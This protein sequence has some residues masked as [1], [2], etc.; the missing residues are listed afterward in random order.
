M[1]GIS[2][3]AMVFAFFLFSGAVQ[4]QDD[5]ASSA[6]LIQGTVVNA[7]TNEGI[8][9]ALVY[10]PDNRFATLTDGQGHFQFTMPKPAQSQSQ[11]NVL[12]NSQSHPIR[13]AQSPPVLAARKPGFIEEPAPVLAVPGADIMIR[14]LPEAIIKGSILLSDSDAAAGISVELFT[15]QVEDGRPRWMLTQE[16]IANSNGEFRFAELRPGS[17]KIMTRELLDT[18]PVDLAPK[19]QIYGFPP[20]SFPGVEDFASG[21]MIQLTAGEVF[22]ADVALKRQPYFRV[23][24]PIA[25]FGDGLGLNVQVL[26]K[27]HPG[28]GYSLAYDANTQSIEGMLPK[29]NYV[30]EAT[31]FGAEPGGGAV[32]LS[33]TG[34]NKDGPTLTMLAGAQIP[35]NVREEFNSADWNGSATMSFGNR[36]FT[37]RKGPRTYL[38]V[39][40]E[41]ADDFL[42]RGGAVLRPPRAPDDNS[43]VLENVQPG[44]YWVR[45]NTGRGYVASLTSGT[46]DLFHE[47]LSV[48]P[49]ASTQISVTL[50]DDSAKLDGTVIGLPDTS[51][52]SHPET[53]STGD[54]QPTPQQ[55]AAYVYA[56]PLPDSSGQYAEFWASS[57]GQFN[58]PQ[59]APGTYRLLAFSRPQPSLPYRDV[60]AMRAYESQ[61]EVVHL[62]PGQSQRVQVQLISG[63]N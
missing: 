54:A 35:V 2:L 51:S 46:T 18:D 15:P 11:N 48:A 58:M 63:D 42:D 21:Q 9:R 14:L 6:D 20:S 40:L 24:I 53:N 55:P 39:W 37:F 19:T 32:N 12:Y 1:I 25:N 45:V 17:Y 16:A 33:V 62:T 3:P 29:G 30:V 44:R 8:S 38:N 50:R 7:A 52:Q 34:N 43:L 28:P 36:M 57:D 61:G 47:P 41:S 10:S 26:A 56:V 5:A 31:S 4:A 60:E 59:M 49:G 13:P 22:Q 23:H 27:G